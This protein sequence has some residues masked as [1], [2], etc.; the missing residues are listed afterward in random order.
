MKLLNNFLTSGHSFSVHE[1]LHKFRF[2]LLNS[3]LIIVASFTL[4]NYLASK[5]EFILFSPSYENALLAYAISSLLYIF[6]LRKRK[7]YYTSSV[8][9]SIIGAFA[10][11]Y[12]ALV[13]AVQDEFRL[14]WFFLSLFAG[15]VLIGKKYGLFLMSFTLSII[16]ITNTIV[17]LGY[18]DLALFTF[19]NSFLIFTAFAYAFLHK[20]EN[21]ALEF[22]SL[23]NQLKEKVSKEMQQHQ[24]QEKMLLQQCRM[25]SMGE[26]IDSIAHQWRQPLMNIN[27]ILMN[28][29]RGIETKD[30]PKEYLEKKMNEVI[31]LTTHMSQTIEDFRSLFKTGKEKT[32]FDIASPIEHGLELFRGTTKEVKIAFEPKKEVSFYG[33]YNE[34]TQV[35]IILLSNALEALKLHNPT[36]KKIDINIQ[37]KHASLSISIEDNAGG[38]DNRYIHSIFDPYFTTKEGTGGTGLGLYVAKIIIEQNM[39]GEL[40]VSNTDKGAKF[41]ISLPQ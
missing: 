20:I 21:D 27:A 1:N 32:S 15:F 24:E 12:F 8:H 28:M 31:T 9:L 3:L 37:T 22:T 26:M 16:F 13:S 19:F 17:D 18:T 40:N 39:Q 5:F 2:A 36:V 14:I 11:F 25:A 29:E 38:I 10:L 34:L 23:N 4:L 7:S 35:I 33:H 30:A 6:F 41:I